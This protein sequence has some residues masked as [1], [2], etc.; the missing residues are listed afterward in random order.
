MQIF[1][2]VKKVSR[3]PLNSAI[4]KT[5][6]IKM[7]TI[8]VLKEQMEQ[9]LVK[10][11]LLASG[12]F[13]EE[14]AELAATLSGKQARLGSMEKLGE[15]INSFRKTGIPFGISV[16]ENQKNT[17][18]ARNNAIA[19]FL[20][21]WAP[22]NIITWAKIDEENITISYEKNK[23]TWLIIVPAW[24]SAGASVY[25]T[26][27]KNEIRIQFNYKVKKT[28]L[29]FDCVS[30]KFFNAVA[31]LSYENVLQKMTESEK[32]IEELRNKILLEEIKQKSV[33]ANTKIVT[34][35]VTT[36]VPVAA[37]TSVTPAAQATAVTKNAT[38]T[39][40]EEVGIKKL[41]RSL[42]LLFTE[43]VLEESEK[44]ELSKL[45]LDTF[46][47]RIAGFNLDLEVNTDEFEMDFEDIFGAAALSKIRLLC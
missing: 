12:I 13:N 10:K 9:E 4:I 42:K 22:E 27:F 14:Y 18:E 17:N 20:R 7:S 16:N 39:A 19:G 46:L 30:E 36:A 1:H 23:N 45:D 6:G 37:A 35:T 31:G 29:E 26:P 28:E 3:V 8:N 24:S 38:P 41:E 47:L 43:L 5:G 44:E 25:A 32:K 21:I 40:T 2:L 34:Q 11:S 15:V 33:K